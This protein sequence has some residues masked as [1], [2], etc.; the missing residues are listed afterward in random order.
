MFYRVFARWQDTLAC[1]LPAREVRP[2]VHREPC[3][4]SKLSTRY[5]PEDQ[6][7]TR[8]RALRWSLNGRLERLAADLRTAGELSPDRLAAFDAIADKAKTHARAN[9]WF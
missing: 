3:E 8:Q 9:S 2:C 1:Q 7:G 4:H 5:L 6:E